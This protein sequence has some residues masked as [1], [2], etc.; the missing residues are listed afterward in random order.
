MS[1]DLLNYTMLNNLYIG[2]YKLNEQENKISATFLT[3]K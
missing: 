2:F 1:V 3:L